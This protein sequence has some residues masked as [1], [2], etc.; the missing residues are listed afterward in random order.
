MTVAPPRPMRLRSTTSTLA[1]E[2]AAAMAAYMPAAPEPMMSTSVSMSDHAA[3]D[4]DHPVDQALGM[5][6]VGL[7]EHHGQP[8]LLQPGDHFGEP[9]RQ[10]RRHAF[11]R[12]VEQQHPGA[13][14]Q[15]APERR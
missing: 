5:L 6:Q 10:R 8:F 14:H 13:A 15:R 11:E 4:G 1:P 7:G 9:L 12:L 2:R 3:V